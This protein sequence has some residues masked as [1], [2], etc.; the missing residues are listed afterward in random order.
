[1][2]ILHKSGLKLESMQL[3][4]KVPKEYGPWNIKCQKP[5]SQWLNIVLLQSE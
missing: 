4:V 2:R 1:M 3:M 5:N